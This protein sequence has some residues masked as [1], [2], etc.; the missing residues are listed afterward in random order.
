MP[1]E[2]GEPLA[3]ANGFIADMQ[4]PLVSFVDK[5]IAIEMGEAE[6]KALSLTSLRNDDEDEASNGN[7]GLDGSGVHK[8]TSGEGG[9]GEDDNN[10]N[11][12]RKGS[13]I[14]KPPRGISEPSLI[15]DKVKLAKA[16]DLWYERP[17]IFNCISRH[18]DELM[19]AMAKQR[20]EKMLQTLIELL[21]LYYGTLEVYSLGKTKEGVLQ[22]IQEISG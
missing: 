12:K 18:R 17:I 6:M 16:L 8:T 22:Q 20:K 15:E 10:S 1:F 14:N 19:E 21:D 4:K 13:K 7:G 5:L 2:E 9:G 3:W 11:N